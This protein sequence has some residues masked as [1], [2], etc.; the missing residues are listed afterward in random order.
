MH[1]S[2]VTLGQSTTVSVLNFSCVKSVSYARGPELSPLCALLCHLFLVP[3]IYCYITDHPKTQCLKAITIIFFAHEPV[4][5]AGLNR[6][7]SPLLH[8]ASAETTQLRGGGST[9]KRVH[10]HGWEVG[11]SCWLEAQLGS[12]H[13]SLQAVWASSQ[14]GGWVLRINIPK[15]PGTS[16]D[17]W[18]FYGLALEIIA[19][20]P[21]YSSC[22]L[23]AEAITNAHPGQ[24]QGT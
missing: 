5:C 1:S 10:S 2:C 12:L 16:I 21:L 18:H 23:E 13:S 14:H 4:I 9:S 19:L 11:P 15:K 24:G 20:P 8:T 17:K 22:V 6:Y 7:S 3:V